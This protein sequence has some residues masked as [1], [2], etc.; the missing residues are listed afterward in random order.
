MA[1]AIRAVD[2]KVMSV[3]ISTWPSLRS[4]GYDLDH[5]EC[6]LA[7][8]CIH[9]CICICIHMATLPSLPLQFFST[10]TWNLNRMWFIHQ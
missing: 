4:D 10:E 8:I 5:V 7:S 3:C 2:R 9:L 6:L 1:M